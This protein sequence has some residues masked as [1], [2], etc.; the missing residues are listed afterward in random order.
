MTWYSRLSVQTLQKRV[1]K[2]KWREFIC[3]S[4]T[5][6]PG[7]ASGPGSP[8]YPTGPCTHIKTYERLTTQQPF[9][10]YA[11]G[12]TMV[13][14]YGWP[15]KTIVSRKTRI[16]WIPLQFII[17]LIISLSHTLTDRASR[18]SVLTRTSLWAWIALHPPHLSIGTI[19]AFLN[20]PDIPLL[21]W[22]LPIPKQ[23]SFPRNSK[24][25]TQVSIGY[26]IPTLSPFSPLGPSCPITPYRG[27]NTICCV[28]TLRRDKPLIQ[29][30]P[31]SP[32]APLFLVVPCLQ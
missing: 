30:I 24:P 11:L 15:K 4:L 22:V 18:I 1:T 9:P 6:G 23:Q 20:S 19:S 31:V 12:P 10:I 5:G 32:L 25:F 17:T 21:P 2:P 7:R 13:Q 27:E 16:C 14:T 8:G 29:C 28:H 26:Y 3:V